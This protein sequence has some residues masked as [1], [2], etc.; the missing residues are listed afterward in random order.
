MKSTFFVI[1]IICACVVRC[2][3]CS[4]GQDNGPRRFCGYDIVFRGRAV[5]EYVDRQGPADDP[6][7]LLI[8]DRVYTVIVDQA[9]VMPD[10]FRGDKSIKIRTPVSGSVC[11][12]TFP[13]FSSRVFFASEYDGQVHTGLCDPNEPWDGLSHRDKAEITEHLSERC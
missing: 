4:C 3:G 5:S 7:Y 11:G 8:S 1:S 10:S 12:T 13:L 2:G 9:I 6:F